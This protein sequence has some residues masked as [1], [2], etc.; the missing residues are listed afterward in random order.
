M[1]IQSI[2]YDFRRQKITIDEAYNTIT[3]DV[4]LLAST[5]ND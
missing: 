2:E 3:I 4:K 5:L 1:P